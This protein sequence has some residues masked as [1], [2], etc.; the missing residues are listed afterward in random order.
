MSDDMGFTGDQRRA[1]D[2]VLDEIIPP[3]H[4]G[5]MPGAGQLGL[6]GYVDRALR[7]MPELRAMFVES[8]SGLDTIAG[9]RHARRFADLAAPEQAEVI[10]EHASSEHAFPPILVLH[11]YSG[12]YQHARVLEALGLGAS[13]PHPKGYV[14]QPNDLSL[15]DPVRQRAPM[16]R[17]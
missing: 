5:R 16:Y 9:R 3:S 2:R 14:M 8:V 11:A 1:I 12:Y 6:A 15:L 17:T 10:N 13:P 4:D 7:S